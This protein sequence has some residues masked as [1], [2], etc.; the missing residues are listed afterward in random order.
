MLASM[1]FHVPEVVTGMIGVGFI[2][3]S[4]WSSILFRKAAAQAA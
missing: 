3:I 1:K 2:L 4:L